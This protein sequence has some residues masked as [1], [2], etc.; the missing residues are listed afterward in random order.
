MNICLNR[1][2]RNVLIHEPASPADW[3][4]KVI[5]TSFG[6]RMLVI[7]ILNDFGHHNQH[8]HSIF[9]HLQLPPFSSIPITPHIVLFNLF[10]M[11]LFLMHD[12]FVCYNLV[13]PLLAVVNCLNWSRWNTFGGGRNHCIKCL[14][15]FRVALRQKPRLPDLKYCQG[16]YN[17]YSLPVTL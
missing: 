9:A 2:S 7:P 17:K 10:V 5:G 8:T 12:L 14:P 16:K 4:A 6:T 11:Q 15:R 13:A 3:T 1:V